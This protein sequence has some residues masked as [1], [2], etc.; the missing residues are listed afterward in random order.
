MSVHRPFSDFS[1]KME[2]FFEHEGYHEILVNA[3][4]KVRTKI[5]HEFVVE[6]LRFQVIARAHCT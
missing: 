4:D 1:I 6:I 5:L 2:I 3:V